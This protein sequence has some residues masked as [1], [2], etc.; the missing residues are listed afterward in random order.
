MAKK[1]LLPGFRFHPNDVEL[2]KYYLKRKILGFPYFEAIQEVSLYNFDPWEIPDLSYLKSDDH[3]WYFFC[4]RERRCDDGDGAV[5]LTPGGFWKTSGREQPVMYN[6][7]PIGIIKTLIFYHGKAPHGNQTDWVMHEYRLVDPDLSSRGIQQDAYV[8]CAI[9][10]K[11]CLG[12][13]NFIQYDASFREED[14]E[15]NNINVVLPLDLHVSARGLVKAH[16]P[17]EE[18]RDHHAVCQDEANNSLC[19]RTVVAGL[20][21][22]VLAKYQNLCLK[23][24]YSS[25]TNAI[26]YDNEAKVGSAVDDP[27]ADGIYIDELLGLIETPLV[28]GNNQETQVA[29]AD[30]PDL[31][32]EMGGHLDTSSRIQFDHRDYSQNEEFLEL[33]DLLSADATISPPSGR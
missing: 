26:K 7:E 10:K 12:P 21:P 5:Y 18:Q 30:L 15:D 3:K 32:V 6:D 22:P 25:P 2:L 28:N 33:L 11:S 16:L 27:Y 13:Y 29:A 1:G 9:S 19:D 31:D 24:S 14:W 8:V 20:T 23:T 4:S 17:H